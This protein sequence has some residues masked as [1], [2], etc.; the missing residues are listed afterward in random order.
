[1]KVVFASTPE[2]VQ[3][4]EELVQSLFSN[5]FPQY[6]PDEE[7]KQFERLQVLHTTS[8]HSENF[9][10]LK[11]A[12]QVISSLQTIISILESSNLDERYVSLFEKNVYTL[13]SFGLCFPFSYSHFC[14]EK[15]M[16]EDMLSIYTKAANE[17]LI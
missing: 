10:T 12:Y 15:M 2:Q 17:L 14:E 7:I 8:R 1:M 6:F 9:T 11:E 5:I 3:K 4:I 13:Q 16:K